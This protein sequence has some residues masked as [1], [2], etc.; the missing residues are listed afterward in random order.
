MNDFTGLKV[1]LIEDESI[2]AMMLE[3]MLLE[4]GFELG[5]SAASLADACQ[6]AS[7]AA[8]DVALLDVNLDGEGVFPVAAILRDRGVP[9]VFSTGYGAG[10]LDEEFKSYPVVCKPFGMEELRGALSAALA[11]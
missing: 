9:F 4:L 7:S 3:D 2:V 8:V 10:G 6:I 1:L 11:R 5:G